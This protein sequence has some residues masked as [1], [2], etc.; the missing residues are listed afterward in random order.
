MFDIMKEEYQEWLNINY[1]TPSTIEKNSSVWPIRLGANLAKAHYHIGPRITPYYYLICII[2]GEGQFIQNGQQFHLQKN[3]IF[4]L[5]PQVTHEYYTN[6]LKPLKKVFFAFDG[7]QALSILERI[8][9]S[10]QFPHRSNRMT[11]DA[12]LAFQKMYEQQDSD[13][14]RMSQM[15]TIFNEL[16]CSERPSSKKNIGSSWLEKG[17]EYLEIHYADMI[18]IERVAHHVGIERTHF[19]KKFQKEYGQS[20]IN[21]LQTL[22]MKEAELLLTQTDYKMSEIA[23]SVGFSDLPTFS[24][25]FKKRIGVSPAQFRQQSK[26]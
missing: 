22:R 9:L 5:F 6:P 24:K 3:D 4:C 11:N 21:Y 8:G 7:K 15:Y 10:P 13:L 23:N 26:G 16:V 25:A 18:S 2:D 17:R 19:S 1:F 12:F 20:P 14:A